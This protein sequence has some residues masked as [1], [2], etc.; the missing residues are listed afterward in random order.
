MPTLTV[1]AA[2]SPA[3]DPTLLLEFGLLLVILGVLARLA[4]RFG[5]SPVPFY[6]LGGLALAALYL[7]VHLAAPSGLGAGDVK[8]AL[9]LGA[10]TGALGAGVWT[11]AALGGG[12]LTSVLVHGPGRRLHAVTGL[13]PMTLP[14]CLVTWGLL[15]LAAVAD[16]PPLQLHS[17]R[18]CHR[19]VPPCRPFCWP[20]REASVRSSSGV[21]WPVAG[22][23]WRPRPSPVQWQQGWG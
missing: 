17:P 13:P 12:A 11:L 10:L 18:R 22:W 3:V 5:F 8:L 16:V 20:C 7:V 1:P 19:R 9:A 14:F 23:C 6:L 15:A 2:A 21:I 4:H